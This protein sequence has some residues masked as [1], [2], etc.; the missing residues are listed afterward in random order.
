[1]FKLILLL[2]ILGHKGENWTSGSLF[3]T[4]FLYLAKRNIMNH[5][6]NIIKNAKYWHIRCARWWNDFNMEH[7]I[8]ILWTHSEHTLNI[9]WIHSEHNLNILWRYAEDLTKSQK[10]ESM[11]HPLSNMDSRDASAS[12]KIVHLSIMY[13]IGSSWSSS[14]HLHMMWKKS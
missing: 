11:T 4:T 3:F 10:H 1:M 2:P 6:W 14:C 12:K 13:G 7:N 9:L 5:L 8:N